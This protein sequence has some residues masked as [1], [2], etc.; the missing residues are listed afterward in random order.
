MR[1]IALLGA[2]DA[3]SGEAA[4]RSEWGCGRST[5]GT[6]LVT[7]PLDPRSGGLHDVQVADG[8]IVAADDFEIPCYWTADQ[9]TVAV[10]GTVLVA[11]LTILT[12]TTVHVRVGDVILPSLH[13]MAENATLFYGV[14]PHLLAVSV[15]YYAIFAWSC[16]I[17]LWLVYL[18]LIWHLRGSEIDHRLILTGA[19]TLGIV[20]VTIPPVF[21]T[22]IF[23]YAMFGRLAAVYHLNPY[24]A[25]AHT[26]APGDLLMPYLYWRD[27]PSPYGPLWTLVSELIASGRAATPFVLTLRFKLVSLAAVLVDGWLVYVLVR[28]RWPRYASWAYMAFAWNP[29]VLVEG[30]VVGHN[31]SL[32]LAVVLASAYLLARTRSQLAFVGLTASGLVKYSTLPVMGIAALRLLLRTP[33]SKRVGL[34][35]RLGLIAVVLPVVT[36]APYWTGLHGLMSTLDEPGRGINNPILVAIRVLIGVVTAGHVQLGAGGTVGISATL[37]GAWQLWELWSASRRTETWGIDDEL[38]AWSLTL[39]VFLLLWPRIHTWYFLVPL[40]LSLAAGPARRRVFWGVLVVTL[41]SYTSYF[42]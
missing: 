14:L 1:L 2:G 42:W 5:R 15:G 26:G 20:A 21:S 31:D 11:I 3:A 38:G 8:A 39:A 7:A 19:L 10:G 23:S 33:L 17:A 37:F 13:Q 35:L 32:I 24:V 4:S 29:M 12:I 16:V 22:D 41:V 28:R 36:F 25:T 27:I 6:V 40:G 9:R 30:V 18:K 34:L